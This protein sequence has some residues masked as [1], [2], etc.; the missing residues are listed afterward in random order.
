MIQLLNETTDTAVFAPSRNFWKL[1][2]VTV[3]E[4]MNRAMITG[5]IE[6][7]RHP[8]VVTVTFQAPRHYL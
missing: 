4:I 8:G 7:A 1:I 6:I 5:S 2:N 3:P